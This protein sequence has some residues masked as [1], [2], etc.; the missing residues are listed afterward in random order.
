VYKV[1][2]VEDEE[3]ILKGL[4]YSIPWT[5]IGCTVVGQGRNG[6][7][8]IE[9]IKLHQPDIVI[10]DINMPIL[11]GTEMLR[12][13]HADYC[14]SAIILSGYS[15]FEYAKDA[16]AYGAIRYLLKPL[17]R[18]E[19][20]DAIKEAKEQCDIRQAWLARKQ[21]QQEWRSFHMELRPPSGVVTDG[22]V[23]SMLDYA[24]ANYQEK[25]TLQSL[26][27]A[28]NYSIAFLNKRFKKQMGTTFIEYLNRLRI[29]KAIDM[30]K[31]GKKPLQEISWKSGIGDYKYFNIVFKKYVGCSPKE[32]VAKLSGWLE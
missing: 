9:Q 8:G 18:G 19:L 31:D 7:E 14:Y 3:V 30:L 6:V 15:S 27:E 22:V 29:Q 28:L 11:S 1:I 16:M 32:Y 2:V 4:V 24:E 23:Q 5:D 17:K 12:Q 26:S 20:F 25:V 21:D 13:T 10:V